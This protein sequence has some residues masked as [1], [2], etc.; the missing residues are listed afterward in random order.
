M[1]KIVV[2]GGEEF[3]LG[4]MLVG[5]KDIVTDFNTDETV[6][7]V[8][9]LLDNPDVGI[10]IMQQEVF[11]EMPIKLKETL[12]KSVKPVVV[13]LSKKG[14]AGNL[15]EMIIKSIGVDLWEK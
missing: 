8:R 14:D 13:L 4:F 5:I 6:N 12:T 3:T 11:D 15:R 7:N 10:I 2:V 9:S 1:S